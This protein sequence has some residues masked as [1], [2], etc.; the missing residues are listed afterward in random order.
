LTGENDTQ[1]WDG[2]AAIHVN[3]SQPSNELQQKLEKQ[4]AKITAGSP[5]K[6]QITR[7]SDP[8]AGSEP[9]RSFDKPS[10]ELAQR[11]DKQ[12]EK[13]YTGGSA[14]RGVRSVAVAPERV[15]SDLAAKLEKRRN[16]IDTGENCIKQLQNRSGSKEQV[17]ASELDRKLQ[18]QQSKISGKEEAEPAAES[19]QEAHAAE[20]TQ[21]VQA[22]EDESPDV[23]PDID[24]LNAPDEIPEMHIDDRPAATTCNAETPEETQPADA[25]ES[26]DEMD[27]KPC[28]ATKDGLSE[29]SQGRGVEAHEAP[30][31]GQA[32]LFALLAAVLVLLLA[33]WMGLRS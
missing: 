28:K 25:D 2:N 16:R 33:L 22:A 9:P 15:Q 17:V 11:L 30:P 24:S 14:V 18:K 23:A 32:W 20:S 8:P 19:A 13:L 21:E 4:N 31:K 27:W 10:S 5:V 7:D 1:G 6:K 3:S 26:A 12:N 29:L